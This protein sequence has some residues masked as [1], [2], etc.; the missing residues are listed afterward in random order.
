MFSVGDEGEGGLDQC[1]RS[2]MKII[3]VELEYR[4]RQFW[5]ALI[6]SGR[7]SRS[8]RKTQTSLFIVHYLPWNNRHKKIS[9]FLIWVYG[10]PHCHHMHSR[11]TDF[12]RSL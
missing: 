2:P 5:K 3:L 11:V 8:K 7:L 10:R 6:K 12:D 4:K 9:V 1:P